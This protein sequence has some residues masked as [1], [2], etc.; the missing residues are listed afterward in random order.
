MGDLMENSFTL[1]THKL[2]TQI[3]SMMTFS[4]NKSE[5]FEKYDEYKRMARTLGL[6]IKAVLVNLQDSREAYAI[7]LE[8]NRDKNDSL[9]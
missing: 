1:E 6:V 7:R 4:K 2:E 3:E 9:A 8:K 5:S